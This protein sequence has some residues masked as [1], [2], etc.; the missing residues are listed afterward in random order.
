LR[1]HGETSRTHLTF[2]P[3][4]NTATGS[5]SYVVAGWSGAAY[6]QHFAESSSSWQ[7][8]WAEKRLSKSFGNARL[9]DL[10]TRNLDKPDAPFTVITSFE[11]SEALA[12]P[13]ARRIAPM[14]FEALG[15]L[16]R[17][18]TTPKRTYPLK[19]HTPLVMWDEATLAIKGGTWVPPTS[20]TEHT[21]FGSYSLTFTTRGNTLDIRRTIQLMPQVVE[22]GRYEEFVSFCKNID[23]AESAPLRARLASPP[24]PE[25]ARE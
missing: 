25:P 20:H 15:M 2:H 12:G 3:R 4:G 8:T 17:Y 18:V 1:E 9:T 7:E 6:K 24:A 13:D 14:G 19:L 11:L 16:K 21:A 5:R 23:T 10:G 22:P